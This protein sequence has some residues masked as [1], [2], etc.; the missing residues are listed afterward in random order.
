MMRC[1]VAVFPAASLAFT[2]NLFAELGASGTNR[3]KY[4]CTG[5]MLARIVDQ[6]YISTSVAQA[7]FPLI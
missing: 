5:A 1:P 3:L 7:V 6:V 2:I 4:P